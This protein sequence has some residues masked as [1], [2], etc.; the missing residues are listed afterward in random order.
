MTTSMHFEF[1]KPVVVFCRPPLVF[2]KNQKMKFISVAAFN[3]RAWKESVSFKAYFNRSSE[4]ILCLYIL[5]H[6]SAETGSI[7]NDNLWTFLVHLKFIISRFAFQLFFTIYF[8]RKVSKWFF[9]IFNVMQTAR[10]A[11]NCHLAMTV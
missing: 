11:S 6:I 1:F 8:S 7:L 9:V 5:V 2:R 3:K 4:C 10:C